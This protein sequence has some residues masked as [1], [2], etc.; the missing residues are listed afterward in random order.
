ME[1]SHA[2]MSFVDH[3]RPCLLGAWPGLCR[4]YQRGL[5]LCSLDWWWLL[6]QPHLVHTR[7]SRTVLVGLWIDALP[8]HTSWPVSQGAQS[9]PF[10]PLQQV[11][12]FGFMWMGWPEHQY[13][14][15]QQYDPQPLK[16]PTH[17]LLC[18][19]VFSPTLEPIADRQTVLIILAEVSQGREAR[20]LGVVGPGLAGYKAGSSSGY[21]HWKWKGREK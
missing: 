19:S 18:R 4:D 3:S 10:F 5:G 17:S 7:T 21:F 13:P 1:D 11:P 15:L 8:Y 6:P 20:M 2:L 9:P 12:R 16:G 14:P